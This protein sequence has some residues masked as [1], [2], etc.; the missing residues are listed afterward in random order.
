MTITTD[1][2]EP[3]TY[4]AA[5]ARLLKDAVEAPLPTGDY[6]WT[7]QDNTRV[8]VERKTISDLLGSFKDGRWQQQI[9][10]L[11]EADL[12]VLLLEGSWNLTKG[13]ITLRGRVTPW[14]FSEVDDFLIS[15][16]MLGVHLART[17]N[18]PEAVAR[19][20]RALYRQTTSGEYPAPKPRQRLMS[21]SPDEQVALSLLSALPG[22][23]E[24]R[25]KGLL[26]QH[27]SLWQALTAIADVSSVGHDLPR[28]QRI[29]G[30][31]AEG[32]SSIDEEGW[33]NTQPF[34]SFRAAA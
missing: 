2:R 18:G 19:R 24:K 21:C 6:A 1:T 31:T 5:L 28:W 13:Y 17:E 4:R 30:I 29:L 20:I 9:P 10:R 25:A 15:A 7:G 12:P 32:E 23:G 8:L 11:V 34:S 27:G 26:E 16:Q 33:G 14:R 22:V 3:A